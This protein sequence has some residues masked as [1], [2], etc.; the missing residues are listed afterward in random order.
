[1][2]EFKYKGKKGFLSGTK[3]TKPCIEDDLY[4]LREIKKRYENVECLY[5]CFLLD[6]DQNFDQKAGEDKKRVEKY[7][8]EYNA[9]ICWQ[10]GDTEA[11][12]FVGSAR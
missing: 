5:F 12:G 10:I 1:L 11:H 6:E 9:R 2:L 7:A 8:R 3:K 4:K